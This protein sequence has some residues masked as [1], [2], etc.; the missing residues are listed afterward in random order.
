MTSG[1]HV[2]QTSR[3]MYVSDHDDYTQN[4][5]DAKATFTALIGI[6]CFATLEARLL[7]EFVLWSC[8][9]DVV[10]CV[11]APW[12]DLFKG[13]FLWKCCSQSSS[14]QSRSIQNNAIS[15]HCMARSRRGSQLPSRTRRSTGEHLLRHVPRAA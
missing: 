6:L 14:V 12:H 1:Q 8:V 11:K 2:V 10:C 9:S 7:G 5:L 4:A 15:Q 3:T 13:R